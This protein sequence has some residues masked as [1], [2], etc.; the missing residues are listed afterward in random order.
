MDIPKVVKFTKDGKLFLRAFLL[1]ATKNVNGWRVTADSIPQRIKSFIGAPFTF[2]I[3]RG[4]EPDASERV[5][6]EAD[7]PPYFYDK[8]VMENAQYQERFALG[9]IRD[10]VETDGQYDALIEI[11]NPAA[12]DAIEK[13]EIPL[14][15]SPRI[16]YDTHEPLDNVKTWAGFHLTAVTKPAFGHKAAVSAACYGENE[17]CKI[18]IAS[19]SIENSCGFCVK[20][21]LLKLVNNDDS[22]HSSLNLDGKKNLPMGQDPN[23]TVPQIDLSNYVPKADYEALK[24]EVGTYKQANS[25][26]KKS[27]DEFKTSIEEERRKEKITAVLSA[28]IADQKTRDERIKYFLDAKAA[29]EVVETAYKDF[30]DIATQK[31]DNES[32]FTGKPADASAKGPSY[33]DYLKHE[34]SVIKA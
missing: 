17:Q 8:S 31:A 4:D 22:S 34:R 2:Y 12:K 10:V 18:A 33:A 11:T 25:D 21:E 9:K 32:T 26:L 30:P 15:V 13:N 1:D 24:T 14:L 29:P 28:K 7:H 16:L 5:V 27:F 20:T 6:G 23:S 3:N 19:A